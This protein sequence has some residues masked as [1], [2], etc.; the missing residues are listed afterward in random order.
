MSPELE[1]LD[2]LLGGKLPL[3]AILKLY[4]D[5]QA[6]QRGVVGLLCAGDVRL[7]AVDEVEVPA[8]R[9]RELFVEGA[10]V[11]E[12]DRLYLAITEQG[13]RRIE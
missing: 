13:A 10:V 5:Q 7:S 12:L 11:K 1:T 4:P 2:Q 6:F 3:V 9:R 8:W